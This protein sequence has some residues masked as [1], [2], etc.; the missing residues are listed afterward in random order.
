MNLIS[1]LAN[2]SWYQKHHQK[3]VE[4]VESGYYVHILEHRPAKVTN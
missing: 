2:N 4:L 1:H 3:K